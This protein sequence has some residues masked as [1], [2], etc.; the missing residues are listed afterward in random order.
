[1]R[2]YVR[3]YIHTN[4]CMH[5]HVRTYI[6]VQAYLPNYL[7][8]YI[9]MYIRPYVHTYMHACMPTGREAGRQ[10]GMGRDGAGRG[11]R[12]C[13]SGARWGGMRQ[14]VAGWGGMYRGGPTRRAGA[15]QRAG[16]MCWASQKQVPGG[17]QRKNPYRRAAPLLDFFFF[18]IWPDPRLIRIRAG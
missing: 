17:D 15:W 4:T 18:R 12:A 7:H 2:T 6:H 3:T 1:M 8:T 13:G 11:T 16:Q 10:G 14:G 5:A 9:H